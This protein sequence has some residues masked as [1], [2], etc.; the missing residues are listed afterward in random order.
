QPSVVVPR[1]L[2][3]GEDELAG[4]RVCGI[5]VG[6]DAVPL[7]PR[8]AIRT[9]E[10]YIEVPAIIGMK[11]E[12]EQPALASGDEPVGEVEKG[13]VQQLPIFDDPDGSALLDD[14]ETRIARW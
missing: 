6:R 4:H 5:R 1:R 2:R 11:G 3:H 14:E 12:A 7:H 10:V 8:R 9:G 13:L